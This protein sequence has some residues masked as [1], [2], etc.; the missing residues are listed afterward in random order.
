M[1]DRGSGE[2]F[3]IVLN[4]DVPEELLLA[5]VEELIRNADE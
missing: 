3:E 1:I 5:K 4:V 2:G